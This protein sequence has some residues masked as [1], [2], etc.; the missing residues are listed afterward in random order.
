M[1][2]VVAADIGGTH[3]RVALVFEDGTYRALKKLTTSADRLEPF[4]DQLVNVIKATLQTTDAS[5][6]LGVSIACAGPLDIQSGVVLTPPNLPALNHVPLVA[7]LTQALGLRVWLENDANLAALAEHNYGSGRGFDPLLYVTVSTGIGAGL[8]IDGNIFGGAH[9]MAGELGATWV[10]APLNA[11][12]AE[13]SIIES[14][15]SGKGIE[16]MYA[17]RT[18][19]SAPNMAVHQIAAL[20][21]KNDAVAL[22][23]FA[24]MAKSLAVALA[25]AINIIDPQAVVLGGGV[26]CEAD[27]WFETVQAQVPGYVRAG[28][29][30]PPIIKLAQ[31]GDEVGLLGAAAYAFANP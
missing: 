23:V 10:A 25:N 11:G 1:R 26:T 8:I 4:L 21:R 3:T 5:T 2:S 15:A 6:C 18:K 9:G 22:S 29:S 13:S 7:L 24:D 17:H 27:L 28:S 16:H 12:F 20:A 30:R 14:I 19:Q 31:C